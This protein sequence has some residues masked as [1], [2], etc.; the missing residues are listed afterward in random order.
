MSMCIMYMNIMGIGFHIA[1]DYVDRPS[2]NTIYEPM[3]IYL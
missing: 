3:I 1:Y 2:D